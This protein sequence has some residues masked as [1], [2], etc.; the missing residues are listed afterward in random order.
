MQPVPLGYSDGCITFDPPSLVSFPTQ[1]VWNR[2]ETL[3]RS[4]L[5]FHKS[6]SNRWHVG[7]NVSVACYFAR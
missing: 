1:L 5:R 6:S 2:I 3:P 4:V 7:N